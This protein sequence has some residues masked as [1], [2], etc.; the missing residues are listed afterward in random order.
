MTEQNF[1]SHQ[2]KTDVFSTGVEGAGGEG[3]VQN[4]VL[5]EHGLRAASQKVSRPQ[6]A[7][8]KHFDCELNLINRKHSFEI[9]LFKL[10]KRS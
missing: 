7:K 5:H 8:A 1:S 4:S 2:I 6:P 9:I 10:K 3:Q